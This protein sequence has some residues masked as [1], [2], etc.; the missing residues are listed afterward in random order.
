MTFHPYLHQG[1]LE[2]TKKNSHVTTNPTNHLIQIGREVLG[3]KGPT[4]TK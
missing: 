2:I 1:V 4:T 3:Y